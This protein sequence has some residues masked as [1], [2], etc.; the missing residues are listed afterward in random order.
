LFENYLDDKAKYCGHDVSPEMVRLANEK[1]ASYSNRATVMLT[2]GGAP[3]AE[4]GEAYDRFVSN[5]VFDLL[6]DED[7]KAVLVEAHRILRPEGIL[8]LSGLS[9]G[10]S[11]PT[12]LISGSLGLIQSLVPSLVGGCRP[13]DLMP[14]VENPQWKIEFHEK[15]SAFGV[16]SECV[17]ARRV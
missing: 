1:L 5:Y 8:C 17:I 7:I 13:I 3:G 16:T 11:L 15:V 10:A 14:Y 9:T 2:V 12:S 6:S 4:P